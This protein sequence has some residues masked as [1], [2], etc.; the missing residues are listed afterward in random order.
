MIIFLTKRNIR[1]LGNKRGYIKGPQYRLFNFFSEDLFKNPQSPKNKNRLKKIKKEL[2]QFD[3]YYNGIKTPNYIL[4]IDHSKKKIISIGNI[5]KTEKSKVRFSKRS[6]SI[7]MVTKVDIINIK[8]INIEINSDSVLNKEIEK[9]KTKKDY[10]LNLNVS[11]KI[12]NDFI[13]DK[14]SN[15]NTKTNKQTSVIEKSVSQHI[16]FQIGEN[17][18]RVDLHEQYGGRRQS[19]ISN[20]PKFPIIFIFT[21]DK[22]EQH[23][24]EDG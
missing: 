13:V 11:K 4:R 17:Y 15:K 21:V 23:G 9:L 20:C 3:R 14:I 12:Y 6:V 16:S 22:H 1:I 2:I 24:Y 7:D 18:K 5:S 10:R 19:G 8:N